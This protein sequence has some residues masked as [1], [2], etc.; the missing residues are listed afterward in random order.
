MEIREFQELMGRIYVERDARRG[1]DGTFRW[2]VE[3]VGELARSLRHEDADR[4]QHELGD[5]LAWLASL[6]NLAGV[7]LEQ[8][9]A[10]YAKGCPRCGVLP[11]ACEFR[12]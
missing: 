7:D 10:R 11:C 12:A 5:V 6:A 2:F 9:A 3:E 4:R 8:A 1:T